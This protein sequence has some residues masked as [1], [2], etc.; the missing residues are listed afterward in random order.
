MAPSWCCSLVVPS[1]AANI[2][3]KPLVTWQTN[4]RV[5]AIMQV[6]T[7][8]F[9]GGK[10]TQ[11]SDH[12]GNTRTVS[13]LAAFNSSGNPVAATMPLPN[14]TVKAFATDGSGDIFFGGSFTKVGASGRN[15]IAEMTTGGTLISKGAW[16]GAAN[17]DVQALAVSGSNLYISGTFTAADGQER[18]SLAAVALTNGALQ[19]WA[20]FV[21]G[22]VDG[23]AVNGTNIVAG[24]FFLNAGSVSGGHPS[25]AAFDATSGALQ[26]GYVMPTNSPVV[27][28][29]EDSGGAIYVG[30]ENNR[31]IGF[32]AGGS[33]IWQQ[34]FDGNVQAIAVSDGKVVAGGHFDNLCSLGSNCSSPVVRLH[35]AALDPA[36]G[37]L[38][39]TWA[40]SINS[41]LGVFALER[42]HDRPRGRRRLHHDRRREPGPPGLPGDGQLGS[43]RH[44]AAH[45]HRLARRDPAEGHNDHERSGAAAR[46]VHRHRSERNLC[47]PPPAQ[48]ERRRVRAGL[49]FVGDGHVQADHGRALDCDPRY[50]ASAADCVGNTSAFVKGPS[51][52][53]TAFQ[54]KNADIVYTR[55]WSR[56]S[57]ASAYG[58]TVH[59]VS[60]A[61]AYAKFRFTGRQVAW[62]ASR[63]A[64][65]GTARVYLD[66]HLTATVD[67]H[68]STPIRR[69]IVFAHA[70]SGDG[71]HTIKI[72][73]AGTHGHPA[74]DVDAFLT[75]R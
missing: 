35:I 26:P 6:G 63:T 30:T 18:T 72:V 70:W 54:D 31:A 7:T 16:A 1:A 73:C 71:V 3:T 8:T 48:H 53:L 45:V 5:L 19:P 12:N 65:R 13:N 38:D 50:Q 42:Y 32:N 41:T 59:M 74:V 64:T 68:S 75:V 49:A 14:D 15:H 44:H 22:R 46:A 24:G 60:K 11:I 25:L 9:V 36:N 2:A 27:S 51:V 43:D 10:F 34:Q 69:R 29:G 4:G 17:G 52:R 28:M 66:G 58:G 39:T 37:S 57:V 40:P 67:L 33:S 56:A 62:V 23:L 47:D 61:G 55:A 21:D 20:P